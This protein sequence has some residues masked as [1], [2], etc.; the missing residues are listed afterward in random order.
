MQRGPLKGIPVLDSSLGGQACFPVASGR[1]EEKSTRVD[2][3][4]FIDDGRESLLD[5]Q[6]EG[7]L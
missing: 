5:T 2:N 4:A 3:M 6:T 1:G 7:K